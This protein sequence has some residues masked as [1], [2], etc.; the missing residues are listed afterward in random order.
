[1][2]V[3]G[4][5]AP[6]KQQGLVFRQRPSYR[7]A[8]PQPRHNRQNRAPSRSSV[9]NDASNRDHSWNF[10]ITTSSRFSLNPML[11]A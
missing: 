1:M 8:L 4:A 5:Q 10:E 7:D 9:M 6:D 3:C 2:T 11:S